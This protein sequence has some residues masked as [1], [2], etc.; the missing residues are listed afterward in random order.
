M[1]PPLANAKD[2]ILNRHFA[3]LTATLSMFVAERKTIDTLRKKFDL[4]GIEAILVYTDDYQSEI[5]ELPQWWVKRG[6]ALVRVLGEEG[7]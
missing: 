4:T 3:Q 7:R 5:Y 1:A 6:K 2:T